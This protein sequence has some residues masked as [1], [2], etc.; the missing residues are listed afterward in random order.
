MRVFGVLPKVPL[1]GNICTIGTNGITGP[2]SVMV[3]AF[4]SEAGGGGGGGRGARV[5]IRA[6]SYQRR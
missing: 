5:I 4:A 6:A 3:R 1:V 2:D